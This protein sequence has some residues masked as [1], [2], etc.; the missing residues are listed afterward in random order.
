MSR[1]SS[2]AGTLEGGE[3]FADTWLASQFGAFASTE[4]A[5]LF[6]VIIIFKTIGKREKHVTCT[7]TGNHVRQACSQKAI[8]S[9]GKLKRRLSELG[10][11]RFMLLIA[12]AL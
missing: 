11:L 6:L 3:G 1:R 12:P 8:S 4:F 9:P 10:T 7:V 5:S 2:F